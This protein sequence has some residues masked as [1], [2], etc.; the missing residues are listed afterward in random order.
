MD[1]FWAAFCAATGV[2]GRPVDV[3]AFGDSAA[4]ADALVDLVLAGTKRA[5]AGAL[6]IGRAHV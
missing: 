1:T 6:E 4:M 3:Y 2:T 5:T